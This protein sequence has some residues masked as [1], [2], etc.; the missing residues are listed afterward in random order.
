MGLPVLGVCY[1]YQVVTVH[2]EGCGYS[3]RHNPSYYHPAAC[4]HH[5]GFLCRP[6][7]AA[8]LLPDRAWMLMPAATMQVMN[9]ASGGAVER[10]AKREDR[11]VSV[12]VCEKPRYGIRRSGPLH[13]PQP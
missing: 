13:E 2:K 3:N 10:A 12:R 1:G 7:G 5:H 6:E 4:L 11:Q 8:Q 9:F